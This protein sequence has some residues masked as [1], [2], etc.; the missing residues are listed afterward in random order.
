MYPGSAPA[1]SQPQPTTLPQGAQHVPRTPVTNRVSSTPSACMGTYPGSRA[2]RLAPCDTLREAAA[3]RLH[4]ETRR[5]GRGD[6]SGGR[7][8]RRS[9]EAPSALYVRCMLHAYRSTTEERRIAGGDAAQSVLLWVVLTWAESPQP[10]RGLCLA[11]PGSLARLSGGGRGASRNVPWRDSGPC[12]ILRRER[13]NSTP[14]A[15]GA[16]RH[17]TALAPM[18]TSARCLLLAARCLPTACPPPSALLPAVAW[19]SAVT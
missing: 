19:S 6:T 5:T 7:W 10:A 13:W 9:T 18:S 15:V 1:A 16:A 8:K 2:R 4:V 14:R 11:A 12:W 3:G 17:M